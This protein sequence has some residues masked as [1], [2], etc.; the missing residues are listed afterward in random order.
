MWQ[1]GVVGVRDN[2]L[3]CNETAFGEMN[4]TSF[5]LHLFILFLAPRLGDYVIYKEK[6]RG[7]LI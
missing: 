5:F 4:D 3:T 6:G 7:Q 1:S 2:P